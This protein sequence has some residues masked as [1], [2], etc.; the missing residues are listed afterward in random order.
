MNSINSILDFRFFEYKDYQFDVAHFLLIIVVLLITR[1]L[2][3]TVRSIIK[4]FVNSEKLDV[5][6]SQSFFLLFK[7]LIYVI[8]IVIVLE[9]I[10]VKITI[11]LA[12]SAA[13]LVG[14]GLGLQ[15][16]FSD[17]ISGIFLLVDGSVKIGDVMEV[18]TLV[19]KVTQINLRTSEILTRDGI[20]IIVPNHKF[21]TENVI[22]WSHNAALT[23]FDVNVGVAYGTNPEKVREVLLQCAQ[24]IK[25]ISKSKNNVPN[26]RLTSFGD[27]SLDFQLLFWS[28]NVF[29]IE[30]T[31]SD[32]RFIIAN[33]F[34]ENDIQIPFPQRD[35]H[36][37]S[38]SLI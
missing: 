8:T 30:Q 13:L 36:I 1:F 23:R 22:N 21:I 24:E 6:N 37:K 35:L 7:Y 25:E 28:K 11:L 31:K 15:Q 18:D 19:G 4:K 16:I 10:G 2:L 33:K 5:R 14:I 17:I 29:L 3:F 34:M 26:V 32:L 12:G 9:I 20:T 27:S 38:G